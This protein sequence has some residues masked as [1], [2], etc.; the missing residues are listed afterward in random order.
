MR[1]NRF[2]IWDKKRNKFIDLDHDDR[3]AIDPAGGGVM[4]FDVNTGE[5]D[6]DYLD[7]VEVTQYT[8]LKDKNGKEIYE[9]DV[10]VLNSSHKAIGAVFQPEKHIV[11]WRENSPTMDMLHIDYINSDRKIG[12]TFDNGMVDDIEIIGNKFEHLELLEQPNAN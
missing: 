5:L 8:G 4:T 11:Q 3:V 2:R 10:V 7:D 12:I 6:I 9:G 1:E